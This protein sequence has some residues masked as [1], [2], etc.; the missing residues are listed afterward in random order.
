MAFDFDTRVDR[1]G[2]WS[3]R[4]DRYAGQDVIPLW[5]ADTDFAPPPAVL[6]AFSR[7]LEHG[8]FGY[9]APPE[10][11]REAIVERLARL[12]GWRVSPEWIV[13][14]PGVV[15]ALHHAARTLM[16]PDAHALVPLPVYHHV[17]RAPALAGRALTDVPLVVD[18]G[19]WVFDLDALARSIRPSTRAFFLCN[20]QNPGGTVFT[21]SELERL[22]AATA[23]ALIISDEIHCDLL[24][25]PGCR[26]VPIASLAPEV[27]RRTV[28]FMSPNKAFNFPGTGCAWAII[29]DAKTRATFAADIEAHIMASASLFGYVGALACLR[30]GDPWLAAQ[31]DYLRGNRDLVMREIDLPI[32]R[33]EATY[34]AWIDCGPLGVADAQEFFLRHGVALS[35]GTQFAAQAS[36]VRLNFGTQRRRLEQALERMK[37]AIRTSSRPS[38]T[39]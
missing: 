28:T 36:F 34:L 19:R 10:A 8:I 14:V 1:A 15:P 4:W 20:P 23:D 27:S 35:P 13:F 31:L 38:P 18:R 26:H 2:T 16:A 6:E 7:R 12:Y 25:E 21:R 24:L 22:A 33:I 9:T 3:T 11:L 30:E 37:A 39:G 5:V 29:E 17:R 32:A